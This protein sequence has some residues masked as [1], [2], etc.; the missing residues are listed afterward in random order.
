VN[1]ALYAATTEGIT[2]AEL[3][4]IAARAYV[5]Q[6]FADEIDKHHQGGACGY[7]TRDWVAHPESKEVVRPNQAFAWNPSITGTKIEETAIL[8]DGE[9]EVITTTAEFPTISTFVA[10]REYFSPGVLSLSK[11]ASA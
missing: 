5:E 10:G 1:A 9:L 8:V 2:G 7:R 11:G 3:Y 6:G 4:D